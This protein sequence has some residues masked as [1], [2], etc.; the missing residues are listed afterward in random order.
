MITVNTSAV[1]DRMAIIDSLARAHA[2]REQSRWIS[3]YVGD[4]GYTY[5][6]GEKFIRDPLKFEGSLTAW[7]RAYIEYLDDNTM[8]IPI[9]MI[10]APTVDTFTA[11]YQ[12]ATTPSLPTVKS[13]LSEHKGRYTPLETTLLETTQSETTDP[14]KRHKK[15]ICEHAEI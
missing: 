6:D 9:D 3:F 14:C 12:F 11:Q 10:E 15:D 4:G 1:R 2:D 8:R 13:T 7:N 5:E